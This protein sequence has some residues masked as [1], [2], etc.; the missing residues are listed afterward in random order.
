MINT[1]SMQ[2]MADILR[3]IRN[4]SLTEDTDKSEPGTQGDKEAYEK[5]RDA[6]L[7]KFGVKSCASCETEEEKKAC[8]KALDDAHVADHEEQVQTEA[9]KIECPKCEGKGCKHCDGKGYHL[10]DEDADPVGKNEEVKVDEAK[11]SARDTGMECM[12]CGKKFR[13]KLSTLQYGKTKCPKCKSTDIDFAFGESVK[14]EV[15]IEEANEFWAVIDKAKGG[16]VMAVS[17][18]EKGAKS[19]VKMSNFSKHDY[20][21]GKDP[22]TLKIVKVAGSYKKGEKMIGT[23]LS[24][25]EEVEIEEV[26]NF[27]KMTDKK[28]KSFIVGFD[29]DERMSQVAGMQLKAAKKEAK[30]RGMKEE[31]EI[32]EGGLYA[33]KEPAYP[34][35]I[36]NLKKI[37]K[38]KQNLMFMFKDGRARVDLFSASAMTQVYDALKKPDHKK[39]FEKMIG[40][41]AGFLQAQGFAMKMTGKGI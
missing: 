25:K 31:V 6:V 24:F 26:I 19:S 7:K 10:E 22:R 5:K 20:H 38:D 17:S 33:A 3:K 27:G 36:D 23:K 13:A 2:K 8:F 29:S 28:L 21:F 16:E 32:E 39:H 37:V 18:D 40:T 14:E 35:T 15:E 41:K 12:E 4:P 30:N 9:N 1:Q 34:P 11:K